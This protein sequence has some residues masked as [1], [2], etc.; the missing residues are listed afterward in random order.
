MSIKTFE[1][2]DCSGRDSCGGF[3]PGFGSGTCK[4]CEGK[5]VLRVP[6]GTR[7][8]SVNTP[9]PKCSG[10]GSTGFTTFSGSNRAICVRCG[11][12]G[13]KEKKYLLPK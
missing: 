7:V 5:T 2:P 11:G 10:R 12:S 6:K 8:I 1:C 3:S 9:C 4:T 13:S